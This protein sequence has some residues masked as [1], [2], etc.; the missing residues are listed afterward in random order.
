MSI[1]AGIERTVGQA[2]EPGHIEPSAKVLESELLDL[3]SLDVARLM[4]VGGATLAAATDRVAGLVLYGP[5]NSVGG[6][7]PGGGQNQ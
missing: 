1:E 4:D 3:G 7:Q 5:E 6:Y 2:I